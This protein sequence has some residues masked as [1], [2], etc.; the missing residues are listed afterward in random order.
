MTYTVEVT[1]MDR[2]VR[3]YHGKSQDK[4]AAI[5]HA[6]SLTLGIGNGTGEVTLRLN[7]VADVVYSVH[8]GNSFVSLVSGADKVRRAAIGRQ[9]R[10]GALVFDGGKA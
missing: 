4:A 5:A 3:L 2:M 7:G 6:A 10:C 8:Q 9:V 1:N